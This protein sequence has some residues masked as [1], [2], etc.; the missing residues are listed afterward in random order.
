MV[1]KFGFHAFKN[2]ENNNLF[3]SKIKILTKM[4]KNGILYQKLAK[5]NFFC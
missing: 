2:I 1:V 5:F 4:A 3:F